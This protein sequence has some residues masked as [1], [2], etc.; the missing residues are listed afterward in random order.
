MWRRSLICR[1]FFAGDS[2]TVLTEADTSTQYVVPKLRASGWDD[3]SHAFAQEH[4]FTDGR[5]VLIGTR[6]KRKEKKRAGFLPRDR[7]GEVKSEDRPASEG[8]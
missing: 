6:I 8:I 5:I 2:S 7:H 1:L 4:S 3:A